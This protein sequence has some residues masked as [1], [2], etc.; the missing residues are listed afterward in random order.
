MIPRLL[1]TGAPVIWRSHVGHRPAQRSRPRG[2]ALPD[3]LRRAG[4]RLR[5]LAGRYVWEG[6]DPAKLTIIPPSIDAF[7]PKNHA[8]SYT[9][10]TAVLRAAGLAARPPPAQ[11]EGALRAARRQRRPGAVAGAVDRGAT[12]VAR[13]ARCSRR[14]RAGTASRIRWACSTAF[15]EHVHA[16]DDQPHLLLAGPDVT[17]V[18]D[19]PEGQEVFEEIHEL[20]S[21]LPH[22]VPPACAPGAAADGGRR[23]ERRDRQRAAAAR[24]RRRAEE[25]RRGVRP[26]RRRGDVEG[27][28][29]RRVGDRRD[30]SS[31]SRTDAPATSWTPPTCARSA[32]A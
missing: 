31:R 14:S 19:D 10:V 4:R 7:S 2:L 29:G 32:S 25:P 24:R 15:A 30:P 22:R 1:E 12:A 21:G 17:A 3:A 6:L 18:A 23:R 20:W 28:P 9:S 26:D 8:M 13:R 27:P 5:L 16:E 11:R